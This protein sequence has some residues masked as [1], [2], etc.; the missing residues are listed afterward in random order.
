MP[1][2]LCAVCRFSRVRSYQ[3]NYVGEYVSAA[4]IFKVKQSTA[5]AH[6]FLSGFLTLSSSALLAFTILSTVS[7]LRC[8][9]ADRLWTAGQLDPINLRPV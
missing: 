4:D 9:V 5:L 1:S 7:P 3:C 6:F 2:Y 8:A